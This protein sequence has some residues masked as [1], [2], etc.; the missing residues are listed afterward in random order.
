VIDN[1]AGLENLSR[2]IVR[3][4][5]LMVL[6]ADPSRQ[7]LETVRRLFRLAREM[8]IEIKQLILVINRLREENLPPAAAQ[9]QAELGASRLLALPEDEELRR[10]SEAGGRLQALPASNRL[11]AAMDR[12]LFEAGVPT[13]NYA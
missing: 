12:L 13:M 2:R 6:V 7:G 3:Q 9:L 10:L 4:L 1:E 11:V 8:A 5:D